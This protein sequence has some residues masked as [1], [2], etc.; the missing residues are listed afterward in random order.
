MLTSALLLLLA[1]T[2]P[3]PASISTVPRSVRLVADTEELPTYAGWSG[4]QLREEYARL[5]ASR[6]G[7]GPSIG[8][9]SAGGGTL[10]VSLYVLVIGLATSGGGLTMPVIAAFGVI[11]TIGAAVMILGFIVLS[12]VLPD[13]KLFGAQMDEVERLLKES[14]EDDPPDRRYLPPPPAYH[15]QASLRLPLVSFRF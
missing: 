9:I 10:V 15:P 2:E 1:A 8:L 13:R 14:G 12:R 11:A 7:I 5:K 4:A 3:L 6:P